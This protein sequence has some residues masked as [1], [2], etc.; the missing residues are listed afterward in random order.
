VAAELVGLA[1]ADDVSVV[2]A[3]RFGEDELR[4]DGLD[5]EQACQEVKIR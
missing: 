3:A 5:L 4:N 2:S 1:T